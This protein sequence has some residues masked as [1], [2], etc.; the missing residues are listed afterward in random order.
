VFP[1]DDHVGVAG[2]NATSPRIDIA[3]RRDRYPAAGVLIIRC[4]LSSDGWRN[5]NVVRRPRLAPNVPLDTESRPLS[6]GPRGGS[7]IIISSLLADF[8]GH[9]NVIA[10]KRFSPDKTLLASVIWASR[11]SKHQDQRSDAN[12]F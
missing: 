5:A 4:C 11:A 3:G 8:R 12:G 9:A 2:V 7:A 1:Y 6:I 10:D